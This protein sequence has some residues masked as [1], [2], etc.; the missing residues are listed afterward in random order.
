MLSHCI[1]PKNILFQFSRTFILSQ[2]HLPILFLVFY[3]LPFL[4]NISFHLLPNCSHDFFLLW[5]MYL[6]VLLFFY[7]QVSLHI[8]LKIVSLTANPSFNA[9]F[10]LSILAFL[11]HFQ[12]LPALTTFTICSTSMTSA[13]Y[14]FHS[15][16]KLHTTDSFSLI[17]LLFIHFPI[18]LSLHSTREWFEMYSSNPLTIFI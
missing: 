18:E 1:D 7:S 12:P 8:L 10:S 13:Y 6:L 16:S 14:L 3:L 2:S 15:L 9:V 5:Y 11:L 17:R 4:L